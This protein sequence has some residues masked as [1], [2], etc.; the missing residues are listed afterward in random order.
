MPGPRAFGEAQGCIRKCFPVRLLVLLSEHALFQIPIG[1]L[2]TE[3]HREEHWAE[4]R[5]G[6]GQLLL[7]VHGERRAR[8]RNISEDHLVARLDGLQRAQQ[9]VDVGLHR[10]HGFRRIVVERLVEC[11]RHL[12]LARTVQELHD[13]PLGRIGF[14]DGVG[15][16][17]LLLKIEPRDVDL[18]HELGSQSQCH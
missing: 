11:V 5:T 8:T 17:R 2:R 10:L 12:V 3:P 6:N 14:D 16:R 9:P 4:G 13:D 7:A 1:R 15:I 18:D